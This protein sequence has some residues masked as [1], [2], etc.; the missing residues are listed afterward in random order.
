MVNTTGFF[1]WFFLLFVFFMSNW[2]VIIARGLSCGWACGL[3]MLLMFCFYLELS[4]C[5]QTFPHQDL[6]TSKSIKIS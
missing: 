2:R 5:D 3:V 4:V 1:S 6:N